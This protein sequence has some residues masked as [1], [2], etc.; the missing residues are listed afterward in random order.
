MQRLSAID[1]GLLAAEDIARPIHGMT[2]HLCAG[3]APAIEEL[4]TAV[5][6][7]L[8]LVPRFRQVVAA[9]PLRLGPPVWIDDEA[10]DLGYHVRHTALPAPGD[11]RRLEALVDRLAAQPLDPTRP[12][13]ELWLVEGVAGGRFA[14]ISKTH[15]V[16]VDGE[17]SAELTDK[18]FTRDPGDRPGSMPEWRAQPRPRAARLAADRLRDAAGAPVNAVFSGRRP[19]L[20]S[21]PSLRGNL[22]GGA[23]AAGR[24]VATVARARP[25]APPAPFGTTAGGRE[26]RVRWVHLDLSDLGRVRSACDATVTEVLLAG[27]AEGLDSWLG[28]R[29]AT[30]RPAAVRVLLPLSVRVRE[31]QGALGNRLS[32]IY[33]V[34]PLRASTRR[35]RLDRVSAAVRAAMARHEPAAARTIGALGTFAAPTLLAQA[36]RLH[37]QASLFDVWVTNVPGPAEPRYCCGRR[38]LEVRPVMPLPPGHTI[39]IAAMSYEDGLVVGLTTDPRTVPDADELAAAIDAGFAGLVALGVR[40]AA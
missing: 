22:A 21:L 8:A 26:R 15:L 23:R 4:R 34:I 30:D 16:L 40:R 7:R 19:S 37:W 27:L 36:A 9:V 2:V 39:S 10:F 1:T 11:E 17:R 28:R 3:P 38:I 5:G 18:L 33:P 31:E 14:L 12:L 32:A 13:W 6:A 25:G 20:P 29:G 35:R 24:A